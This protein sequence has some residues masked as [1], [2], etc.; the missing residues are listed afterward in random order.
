M[1]TPNRDDAALERLLQSLSD[2]L[3]PEE[4]SETPV[5]IDSR[6]SE[7]DTPLHLLAWRSDVPGA[8]LL[9]AAG[10]DQMKQRITKQLLADPSRSI[11]FSA[12]QDERL[13]YAQHRY[14]CDSP[15]RLAAHLHPVPGNVFVEH[16][17][18]TKSFRSHP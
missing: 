3:F 11:I 10:A 9:L 7:D 13:S 1:H 12:A 4:L 6:S 5:R 8:R 15:G 18:G 17:E 2:V 16:A 14:S